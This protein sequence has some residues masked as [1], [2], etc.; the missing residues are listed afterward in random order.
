MSIY[1]LF[2]SFWEM[3]FVGATETAIETWCPMFAMLS[4]VALVM[5]IWL[6]VAKIFR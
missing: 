6:T 2:Y 1:Q 5:G 4:V 3:C